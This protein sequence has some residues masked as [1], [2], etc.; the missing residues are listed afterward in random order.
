MSPKSGADLQTKAGR[1]PSRARPSCRRSRARPRPRPRPRLRFRLRSPR[2]CCRRRLR[3]RPCARVPV[4]RAIHERIPPR[5]P[6]PR[7]PSGP[8][9]S[10]RVRH[11]VHP[12]DPPQLRALPPP[13]SR[14]CRCRH[15]RLLL[16]RLLLCRSPQARLRYQNWSAPR[17]VPARRCPCT[18]NHVSAHA[19]RRR[20][21]P[22]EPG[23]KKGAEEKRRR[24]RHASA[25]THLFE[26]L[27]FARVVPARADHEVEVPFVAAAVAVAGGVLLLLGLD[28]AE[29]GVE[30]ALVPEAAP[31]EPPDALHVPVEV[32]ARPGQRLRSVPART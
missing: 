26:H 4:L 9:T 27:L 31:E 24:G 25:R 6:A 13:L 32:P 17:P 21:Q 20:Q 10:L 8:W 1:P 18:A 30:A 29:S 12:P 22:S 23:A 14:R 16:R 15:S 7:L 3:Q 5:R 2:R 28:R 19:P 11:R